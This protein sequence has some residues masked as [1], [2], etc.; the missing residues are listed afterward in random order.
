MCAQGWRTAGSAATGAGTSTAT[1]VGAA[2]PGFVPGAEA[3]GGV[4]A[5]PGVAGV[6]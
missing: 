6:A 2:V 1:G 5:R 3:A 4:A